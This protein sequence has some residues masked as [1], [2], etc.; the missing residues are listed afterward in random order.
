MNKKSEEATERN[1]FC[2][3]LKAFLKGDSFFYLHVTLSFPNKFVCH[4]L[5]CSLPSL[6]SDPLFCDTEHYAFSLN[7]CH[8][9]DKAGKDWEVQNVRGECGPGK[10]GASVMGVLVSIY[11]YFMV[12]ELMHRAPLYTKEGFRK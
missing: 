8:F 7:A 1:I 6:D 12:A 10:Y 5:S 2:V 4:S 3:K 11:V 9:R